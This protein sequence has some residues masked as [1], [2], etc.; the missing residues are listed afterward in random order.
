MKRYYIT[1]NNKH[2]HEVHN[3]SIA[4]CIAAAIEFAENNN[5]TISYILDEEGV[6]Y[7]NIKI[8]YDTIK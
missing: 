3:M 2:R 4:G 7:T 1:Y 6:K 8:C 5:T